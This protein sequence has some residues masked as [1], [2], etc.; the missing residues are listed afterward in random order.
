[1]KPR[2][3][4]FLVRSSRVSNSSE[5]TRCRAP[6]PRPVSSISD[7]EAARNRSALS[8]WKVRP[9]V[10]STLSLRRARR[11][12]VSRIDESEESAQRLIEV[13]A[14]ARLLP[15]FDEHQLAKAVQAVTERVLG[16]ADRK[17]PKLRRCLCEEQEQ[18]PVEITQRLAGER[19]RLARGQRA[20]CPARRG[21]GRPRWR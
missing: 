15:E 10:S 6:S 17:D 8:D 3:P 5:S 11:L 14:V 13:R 12:L 16:C 18:H 1:M 2:S 7:V 4:P 21:G 19:V 9:S 20:P